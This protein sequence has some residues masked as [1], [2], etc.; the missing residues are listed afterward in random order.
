MNSETSKLKIKKCVSHDIWDDFIYSSENKNF[1]SL[2]SLINSSKT[3]C[4]KYLI[5]KE[6]E[7]VASFHIYIKDKKIVS[8]DPIKIKKVHDT[9]KFCRNVKSANPNWLLIDTQA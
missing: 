2:S 9:W 7:I 1:L 8:G 4:I 3:K 5:Y 6:K